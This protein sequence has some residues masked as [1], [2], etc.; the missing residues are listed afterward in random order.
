MG[1]LERLK[2]KMVV[3]NAKNAIILID[4]VI[5]SGQVDKKQRV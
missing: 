3:K 1:R 4:K 2:Q 5:R